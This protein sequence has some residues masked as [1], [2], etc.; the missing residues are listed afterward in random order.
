MASLLATGWLLVAAV[1]GAQQDAAPDGASA[2]AAPDSVSGEAAAQYK[3]NLAPAQAAPGAQA[4]VLLTPREM[5]GYAAEL[6]AGALPDP[7]TLKEGASTYVV[8]LY[9]AAAKKKERVAALAMESGSGRAD[10]DILWPTFALVVTAEPTPEPAEWSG[11]AVLSGQPVV[12]PN[13]G[14]AT[15][16]AMDA[17]ADTAAQVEAPGAD[18]TVAAGAPDT[19]AQA[20]SP[21]A[22]AAPSPSEAGAEPAGQPA[23]D[24]TAAAVDY[25]V[26]TSAAVT[27]EETAAAGAE[28]GAVGAEVGVAV[29]TEPSGD[30][31]AGA[32]ATPE[33]AAA[34]EGGG[35]AKKKK[36]KN[37]A[38]DRMRAAA[39]GS[40]EPAVQAEASAEEP[41]ANA[42]LDTMAAAAGGP[43]TAAKIDLRG[44]G[45]AAEASGRIEVGS[46][47]VA[48]LSAE[49]LPD[50]GEL[51]TRMTVFVLWAVDPASGESANLGVLQ[52][53]GDGTWTFSG[54]GVESG[55]ALV[56]TAEPGPQPASRSGPVVLSGR[57]EE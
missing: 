12:P 7:A 25:G 20:A 35:D 14:P 32:E 43:R 5:G 53:G 34:P 8:W 26:D 37:D 52:S 13:P 29:E 40:D 4:E 17:D 49:D 39:E 57:W 6:Q 30:A 44:G 18:T 50:P 42:Q 48:R 15:E 24:T 41:A 23:R 55:A 28:A 51:E 10:F 45:K 2:A 21:A 22:S 27:A 1:A 31:A 9:D 19:T 46:D 36:F 47:G 3:F 56:V 11:V 33:V 16:A 38:L 54:T